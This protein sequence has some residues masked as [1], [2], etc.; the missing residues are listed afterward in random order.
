MKK[1]SLKMY[2]MKKARKIMKNMSITERDIY[3]KQLVKSN[4]NVF[5]D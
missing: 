5:N 1:T 3:W 4:P 2:V